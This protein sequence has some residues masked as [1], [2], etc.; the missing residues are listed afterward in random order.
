MQLL[1]GVRGGLF[2][3]PKAGLLL[4]PQLWQSD[5]HD[6]YHEVSHMGHMAQVINQHVT[7]VQGM[8]LR[9]FQWM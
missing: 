2:L 7:V 9:S 5:E 4:V 8:Q 6:K 3:R 1:R